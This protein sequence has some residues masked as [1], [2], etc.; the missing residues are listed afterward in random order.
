MVKRLKIMCDLDVSEK[1]KSRDGK[2]RFKK[3]GMLDIEL[4]VATSSSAGGFEN[5]MVGNLAAGEPIPIDKLKLTAH[6][7][8]RLE[9][10]VS[11]PYDL[12]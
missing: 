10:T 8:G 7:K 1:R 3:H 5:V 2:V 6:N 9:K 11:K 4:R 12:L